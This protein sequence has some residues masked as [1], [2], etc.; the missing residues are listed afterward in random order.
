[1]STT[2]PFPAIGESWS[3]PV[4]MDHCPVCACR[5]GLFLSD[6]PNTCLCGAEYEGLSRTTLTTVPEAGDKDVIIRAPREDLQHK[7]FDVMDTK[8]GEPYPRRSLA[9]WTVNGT[10][11]QTGPGRHVLFT[12]DGETVDYIAPICYVEDGKL[13]FDFLSPTKLKAPREPPTRGFAYCDFGST[14]WHDWDSF[15]AT[16]E[17]NGDD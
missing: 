9:Y 11:R 10:P 8:R 12:E 15:V 2:N 3:T 14:R 4:G 16:D 13:W 7:V 17:V 5:G 6:E 1:M